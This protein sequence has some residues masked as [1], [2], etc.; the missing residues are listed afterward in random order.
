MTK[1]RQGLLILIAVFA[2]L[3]SAFQNCGSSALFSGT[4]ASSATSGEGGGHG[5]S[6]DGKPTVYAHRDPANPCSETDRAGL[7]LPNKEL[8]VYASKSAQLVRDACRDIKPVGIGSTSYSIA[9]DGTLSYAGR[10]YTVHTPTDMSVRAAQCPSGMSPRSGAVRRNIIDD[11]VDL[12]APNW[13]TLPGIET[14]ADGVLASLP[15]FL[16]TRTSTTE[17]EAYDRW[18][19][20][21]PN[22]QLVASFFAR[23]GNTN[24]VT[25]GIYDEVPSVYTFRMY[26]NLDTGATDIN[27]LQGY[28]NV[29]ATT[30]PI[31]DGWFISIYFTS[32]SY[33]RGGDIGYVSS[34]PNVGASVYIANPQL[35]AVTSFCQ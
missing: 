29:S 3:I 20:F 33:A 22:T 7:A 14:I 11:P 18:V 5:D 17:Y 9:D 31:G 19:D 25:I 15:A 2:L 13:G 8:F 23:K 34:I 21:A 24:L 35:E 32:P 26:V 10:S 30:Q 28:T 27:R 6:Y 16:V 1:R 12:M 4:T